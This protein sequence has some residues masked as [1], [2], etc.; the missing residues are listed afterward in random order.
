M[1]NE[2]GTT[3]TGETP[4]TTPSRQV[5]GGSSRL[6]WAMAAI[7]VIG[8]IADQ[9]SKVWALSALADGHRVPV[10]GD[11]LSLRLIRNSGAA[12][13][14]G[15]EVTWVMTALAVLITLG[16]IWAARKL[17]H[18]AWAIALGLILGGSL[19]NLIDRFFREPGPGRG[20]VVDF[21]DYA[22]YFVG[23]VADIWIVV[24][25]VL[26]VALMV[27]DVPLGGPKGEQ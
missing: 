15:N 16:I 9:A 3:L 22:G 17:T 21:I 11:L 27:K 6:R 4:T 18:P 13:S 14:L 5:E 12:F 8:L 24:G 19:G 2:T 25:A 23:N 1:Q 7:A 10:V 26:V 20:H